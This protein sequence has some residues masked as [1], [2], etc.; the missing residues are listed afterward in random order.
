M[1][2]FHAIS[3]QAAIILM[4]SIISMLIPLVV[5]YELKPRPA[6]VLNECKRKMGL[7]C[8]NVDSIYLLGRGTPYSDDCCDKL[9]EMGL[10]CHNGVVSK[11]LVG[12]P[13]EYIDEIFTKSDWI[14]N[15]C[16]RVL[17]YKERHGSR[18]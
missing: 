3:T 18:L 12:K 4:L 5:S 14:W 11:H 9:I 2:T 13:Q 15:H 16:L 1:A 17:K 6:E 8:G 10:D 7:Q